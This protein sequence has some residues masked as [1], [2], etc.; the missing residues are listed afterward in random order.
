MSV[1]YVLQQV[2]Y[3]V[4]LN[5]SDTGQRSVLLRFLNTAAKELYHISDMAGCLEEQ[6]FKI[7]SNQTISLPPY[8]GQIRAM[9]DAYGHK[10]IGLSQMRPRYNEFNWKDDW[11]NWRVKGT[12]TLQSDLTNQSQL[13]LSVKNVETPNVVV[14]ISGSTDGSSSV[15]ETVV[16][17]APNVQ[18]VNAYLDIQSLTKTTVCQND[19]V[20][21]DIDGN[22]ISYIPNDRLKAEFQIVDISSAPWFP[23]NFN[24]LLGWVEVLF[25]RALPD[26]SLDNQ[27]FPASG[28]DEVWVT[29]CL[30][31]W[32]EE[33][34]DIS[35]ATG[36]YSK[37]QQ[38][39]AQ[40]HEDANR[41]TDDVISLTQHGHDKMGHRVGFGRDWRYAYRI[42]GR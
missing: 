3:K 37:A 4:G 21:C 31:L 40:I 25:K 15:S 7:N 1:N 20:L 27:E 9:R 2:G 13:I 30:Q 35:S 22:Q 11:R 33:Q 41:G 38:M 17:Y 39:L 42:T 10:A 26:Y 8:V 6:Y 28:Y 5:P 14:N 16:M 18:T 24:P 23:P 19:V 32:F 34:K 36:A 29:K 12:R